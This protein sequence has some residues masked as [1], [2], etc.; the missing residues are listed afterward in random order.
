MASGHGA[1][2]GPFR[3]LF[4]PS[5]FLPTQ[6]MEKLPGATTPLHHLRKLCTGGAET[7]A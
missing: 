1:K 5:Y 4:T 7:W 6:A 2:F 3:I